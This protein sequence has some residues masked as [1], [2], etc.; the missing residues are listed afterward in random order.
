MS[1]IQYFIFAL[2]MYT[3]KRFFLYIDAVTERLGDHNTQQLE[4]GEV[5]ML[6][7]VG[8]IALTA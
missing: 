1:G 6:C 7:I 2:I 5:C 3:L 4:G 8:L